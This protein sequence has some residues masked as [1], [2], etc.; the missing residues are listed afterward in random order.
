M[1]FSMFLGIPCAFARNCVIPLTTICTISF[2]PS[3]EGCPMFHLL[4]LSSIFVRVDSQDVVCSVSLPI[5]ALS[6]LIGLPSLATLTCSCQGASRSFSFL[7]RITEARCSFVPIGNILV[8]SMLNFTP[9]AMHQVCMMVSKSEYL[10]SLDKYIVVSSAYMLTFIHSHIPGIWYPFTLGELH[11]VQAS[12]SI[13][14]SNRRQ[15][16]GSPCLTPL[17]CMVCDSYHVRYIY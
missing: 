5:Q 11:S 17:S 14:R 6:D 9:D 4:R 15:D 16:N 3:R 1:A 7:F 13:A 10:S 8:F 12:G 2:F